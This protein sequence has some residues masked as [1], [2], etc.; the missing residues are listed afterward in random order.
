VA[1]HNRH[2]T[3]LLAGFRS[4]GAPHDAQARGT[5]TR[6]SAAARTMRNRGSH[7]PCRACWRPGSC[8]AREPVTTWEY[9]HVFVSGAR[10]ADDRGNGGEEPLLDRPFVLSAA[11]PALLST[12][13]RDGWELAGVIPNGPHE[14]TFTMVLKRP[15]PGVAPASARGKRRPPA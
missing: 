7:V 13:G 8:G 12:L 1:A 2:S 5:T 15:L 9:L 14:G 11:K 10:W 6:W 4:N 3:T